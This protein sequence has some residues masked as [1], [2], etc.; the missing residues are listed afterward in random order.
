[1]TYMQVTDPGWTFH[2]ARVASLA[3]TPDSLHL[4]SGSL[5]THV[6]IWDV[7]T[8]SKKIAIKNAGAGGVSAVAWVVAYC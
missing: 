5:D 7:K 8:P 4:A 6:Y 2:S 1:M 3:W